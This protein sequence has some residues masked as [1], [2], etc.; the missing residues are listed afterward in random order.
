MTAEK[1][2]DALVE[3]AFR[4][5]EDQVFMFGEVCDK[6]DLACNPGSYLHAT[7]TF[8]GPAS[9]T[10]YWGGSEAFATELAAN[11]LG[12]ELDDPA[13][14]M[15][16]KDALKELINVIC[17]QFLTTYYGSEP[18]F[19]LES[20]VVAVLDWDAW[21]QFLHNPA[22]VGAVVDDYPVVFGLRV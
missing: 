7:V 15:A 11:M 13:A 22:T 18:I 2:I 21:S 17:C 12:V 14:D 19:H 3:A 9:G 20:P 16:G 5:L 10:C 8:E 1:Q 4:I 6:A